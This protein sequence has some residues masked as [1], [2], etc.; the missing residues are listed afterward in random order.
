MERNEIL[1][2]VINICNEVFEDVKST[3]CEET[4]LNEDLGCDS[5]KKLIFINELENAFSIS[6][7]LDDS[8]NMKSI[9]D[10]INS[11]E[12]VYRG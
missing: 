5:L 8:I 2:K 10:V 6:F 3:I 12:S 4:L 1:S 7:K 9:S 11:I